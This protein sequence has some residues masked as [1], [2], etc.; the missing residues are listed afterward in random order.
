MPDT[1]AAVAT[2]PGQ[3]GIGIV[4]VSGPAATTIGAAIAGGE[5]PARQVA[6]RRFV[7]A[8][9]ALDEGIVLYFPAP[10]SF[11]GEDVV[12]FQGHGGPMV[13]H[14][15]LETVL[16]HGA[17]LARPGEFTERAFVNGRLDLAQAEAV[18]DLIASTSAAAARGALRSLCGAFSSKV[19]GL[20]AKIMELRVYV[21]ASIDFP[22]EEVEFLE[23]GQVAE[24]I[25]G[26]SASVG[27]LLE[28]GRQGA[29]MSQGVSIALVGAPNAGKSSLLN[30]LTGEDT[31][32]VTDIPGTTRD[33]LKID[34]LLDNLPLRVVDTAGL[35]A[36][37]DPVE[38]E[39]VRRARRQA[40]KADLVLIVR[41]L[42][43]P[44]VEDGSGHW[45]Q[46][47]QV[48]NKID[49]VG[50]PPGLDRSQTPPSVRISCLT[51]A[52][53]AD[54]K[55]AIKESVGFTGQGS[56]FSA[57][58]RHLVALNQAQQSLAL[59][60]ERLAAGAPGEI[61]AEELRCAHLALGEITGATAPDDLLG[62]IFS[63]FCIGK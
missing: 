63:T 27:E 48:D 18:A 42:A 13:L 25:E 34:L 40:D 59:A 58:S 57:R 39:G 6:F 38:I 17:R 11:T 60:G 62:E 52:G 9:Q 53:I 37:Q 28:Q 10:G 26:L 45:P 30:R 43:D 2:P 14:G 3:G 32:I 15:V 44:C 47:L 23:S 16:A 50:L 22:D 49:L 46:A 31:A 21:E 41:D 33:L 24:R 19:N 8:E 12:E 5:L 4:R 7:H 55:E 1:I 51:G 36:T 54:L 20:D 56:A 61:V 35:R 29:L